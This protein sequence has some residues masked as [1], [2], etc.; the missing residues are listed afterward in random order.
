MP[1]FE[2]DQRRRLAVA[3][4]TLSIF[5]LLAAASS[6]QLSQQEA[7]PREITSTDF[8]RPNKTSADPA[9]ASPKRTIYRLVKTIPQPG[10][11][12]LQKPS[13]QLSQPA[14][15]KTSSILIQQDMGITFWRLRR[16]TPEDQGPVISVAGDSGVPTMWTPVRTSA[17][18]VFVIGEM[19]RITVESPYDM[20]LYVIDRES[21]TDR[22][23]GDAVL[24]FPTT[25]TRNGDNRLSAGYLIDIPSW[26]DRVPY[27]TIASTHAKYSG[28]RLTFI[29]SP[30]PLNLTIGQ[31]PLT[32][33]V[34]QL[35]RWEDEW[36]VE[37]DSY[38]CEIGSGQAKT[39]VEHEATRPAS[40]RLTQE[41]PLPQTIYR[42]RVR[43]GQPF[44][45]NLSISASQR[46]SGSPL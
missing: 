9:P 29:F 46:P 25:R 28:E 42:V 37:A 17:S 39:Q 6:S 2:K 3:I 21:Y 14:D 44:L 31:N 33:S 24:I 36:G 23:F 16:T 26:T 35:E 15:S 27:F 4:L 38:E 34:E 45:I 1:H 12:R 7:K 8:G 11:K 40:R 20:Y 10:R 22:S 32:V 13:K 5:L 30:A 19:L 41:R 18:H 43:A